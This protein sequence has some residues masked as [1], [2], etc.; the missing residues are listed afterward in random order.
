MS[1]QSPKRK[2]ISKRV[3]FEVFARDNF[4]CRYCGRQSDEVPLHVDHVH[5][6]AKG[7]TND[8]ENL[9]TACQ[10]C[11]LGKSSKTIGQHVPTEA[12]RLRIAQEMNE[13]I[14]S[15]ERARRSIEA[16]KAMKGSVLSAWL[17]ITGK[18]EADPSTITTITRYAMEFGLDVVYEWIEMAE[19]K[20]GD[21]WNADVHMGKY[22]SGIRR[23]VLAARGEAE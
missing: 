11:N 6:V 10:E 20:V 23:Q 3:R 4:T 8:P 2:P 15:A 12:D 21:R 14:E 1:E 18:D 7:G 5:P 22:I 17:E 19:I 16:R 9:V 13:Q